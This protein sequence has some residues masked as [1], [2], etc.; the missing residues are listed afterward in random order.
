MKI[1]L[2]TQQLRDSM[3]GQE[4][5]ELIKGL[6]VDEVGEV[7]NL[8]TDQEAAALEAFLIS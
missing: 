8:L 1:A 3:A 5:R 6:T 7:M 4:V 2:I